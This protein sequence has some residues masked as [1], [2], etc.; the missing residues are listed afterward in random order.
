MKFSQVKQHVRSFVLAQ[1]ERPQHSRRAMLISGQPGGGKS[2]I[3]RTL[4]E[5]EGW[6]YIEIRLAELD[7]T[8]LTGIPVPGPNG[9]AIFL[10]PELIPED[11]GRVWL[12]FV[13]EVGLAPNSMT[14]VFSRLALSGRVGTHRLPERAVVIGA[15]NRVSDRSEARPM[16]RHMANRFDHVTLDICPVETA[17]HADSAGWASVVTG[18]IRYFPDCLQFDPGSKELAW[19]SPRSLE[20][21]SDFLLYEDSKALADSRVERITGIVGQSTASQ[22]LQ[23][24]RIAHSLPKPEDIFANPTGTPAPTNVGAQYVI[25]SSLAAQVTR[26]KM[27]AF[28]T[29]TERFGL[30][31]QAV[32][33]RSVLVRDEKLANC[34]E[35]GD[36]LLVNQNLYKV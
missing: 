5:S 24:E 36:W 8:D 20:A 11:D 13:D 22:F 17:E 31:M 3:M 29:Y 14:G 25:C 7:P 19:T 9:Q 34:R 21:L 23:L 4:A 27:A 18:F 1:S 28:L 30:E 26:H 15:T 33:V 16:G 32:A 12:Y 2:T 10:R 6:G 35:L